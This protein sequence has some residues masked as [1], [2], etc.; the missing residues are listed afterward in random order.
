MYSTENYTITNIVVVVE[1]VWCKFAGVCVFF[2]ELIYT[3]ENYVTDL[4]THSQIYT[5]F[6]QLQIPT[7]KFT[8]LTKILTTS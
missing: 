6:L 2:L 3:C 7:Y 4:Q 8:N 1:S 5:S